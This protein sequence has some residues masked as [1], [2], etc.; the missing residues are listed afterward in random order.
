M[1]LAELNNFFLICSPGVVF[2]GGA[3]PKTE[4]ERRDAILAI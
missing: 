2:F 4:G 3:A 1:L